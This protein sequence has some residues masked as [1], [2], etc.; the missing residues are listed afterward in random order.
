MVS[1]SIAPIFH[2]VYGRAFG[3]DLAATRSYSALYRTARAVVHG[4]SP[5]SGITDTS[6]G[7]TAKRRRIRTANSSAATGRLK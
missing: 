1:G 7:P 2:P 4:A 6:A 3:S 5:D